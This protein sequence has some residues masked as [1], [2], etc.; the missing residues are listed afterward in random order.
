MRQNKGTKY[1]TQTL[2]EKRVL[3]KV[4]LELGLILEKIQS[5][6]ASL[7]VRPKYFMSQQYG[8]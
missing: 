3:Y 4:Q 8:N 1:V 6:T 5:R 2:D 7:S